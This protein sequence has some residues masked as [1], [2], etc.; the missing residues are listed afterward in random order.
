VDHAPVLE[1]I[2]VLVQ[3]VQIGPEFDPLFAGL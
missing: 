3:P 1:V 2:E